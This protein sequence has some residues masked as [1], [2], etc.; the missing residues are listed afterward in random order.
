[1]IGI[2]KRGKNAA[3]ITI[4]LLVAIY[5]AV[6]NIKVTFKVTE[7]RVVVPAETGSSVSAVKSAASQLPKESDFKQVAETDLLRLK[8]DGKTGHFVVEDKRNANVYRS[9]PNPDSWDKEKISET[10]KKHLASPLMVQYVDFS[11][12]ILQAKET[13]LA[14]DGGRVKEVKMI[15]GGFSLVYELPATGFTIP[16][17]VRIENDYVETKIIREGVKETS[18]GLVWA[19]LFPFFGA[20]YTAAGQDSYLFIPDGAGALVRFKDNQL[21]VNKIYDESVYGQ[22][23]TFAGLSNNRNKIVMPVFGMKTGSKGFVAIVHDG[24]EYANIVAAPAGVLSNYNWV[25]TQMNF[26]SSFLQFTSRNTNVPDS[27]GYIDYNRDEVFG[28]DRIVRYYLLDSQK[29]DYVGMAQ[30]YRNYLI[31][32]KGAKPVTVTNPN[33]PMH[34][35]FIGGDQEDGLVTSRYLNL[36]TTDDATHMVNTLHEKGIA[37]MSLTFKGWQKGGYSAFG[38]TFPVDSRIGGDKGMKA[39]IDNAH[40]YGIPVYLEAEYALNNTGASGFDEKYHAIVNLAGRNQ[41]VSALYN[42]EQTPAVSYKFAE[43]MVK[44]D[45]THYKTMGVDGIAVNILGQ[46]LFSDYNS[47]FGS[48]RD[49]ARDVQERILKTIKDSLGSVEGKSANL[50]ALPQMKYIQ[51]LVYDHSY[52]LFTDE[53]VPFVQIATHG[54]VGYSSEYVNNRQEDVHDFLRDIEY[55]AE[56]SFVFTQAESKKYVNS[57]GIRYYNTYFPYWETFAVDQYKRYNEALGNVQDQFIVNHKTI[58]P[59]VKETTYENGTRIIVNYNLE[60][61]RIGDLDVPAQ[62]FVVIRGGEKR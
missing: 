16:I 32:E 56:P 12:N 19:R 43:E 7:N 48:T 2:I 21:N 41:S 44:K 23:N 50:Y 17:E 28:S 33:I 47:G 52:D 53:A 26:R 59:N 40:S 10:W 55:G 35:D 6:T 45:L 9:F 46:S 36:T 31:K 4:L 20:E 39:F 49:N 18:M 38:N 11:K 57:F 1:M 25:T 14:A 27:W 29:S 24:D 3:V 37:N 42:R 60:P 34:V 62:N 30:T 22:D 58:A 15:P 61:Y 51:S 13:N 54:L 8:M 5:L